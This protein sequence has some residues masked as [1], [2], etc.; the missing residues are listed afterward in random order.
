MVFVIPRT[1]L[2]NAT[3]KLI[4]DV[5]PSPGRETNKWWET[6]SLDLDVSVCETSR[7][8]YYTRNMDIQIH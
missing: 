3:G 8:W 7:W 5:K 1:P 6:V 2:S 4:F